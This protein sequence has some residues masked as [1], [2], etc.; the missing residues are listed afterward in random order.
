MGVDSSI[1][2]AI[3]DGIELGLLLHL[4][5]KS[6]RYRT[7]LFLL[8]VVLDWLDGLVGF[9]RFARCFGH[10]DWLLALFQALTY[11]TS[12][13]FCAQNEA[14]GR[15]LLSIVIWSKHVRLWQAL[16]IVYEYYSLPPG[17]SHDG[18]VYVLLI[19]VWF[20]YP[21]KLL[22]DLLFS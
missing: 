7:V 2:F 20:T 13:A 19:W 14:A 22:L 3:P 1:A 17:Y 4:P 21:W 5:L 10:F 15:R 11:F 6:P 9:I 18:I 12:S 8:Q 16:W